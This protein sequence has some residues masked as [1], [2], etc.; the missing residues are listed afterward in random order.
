MEISSFLSIA[1]GLNI[2]VVLDPVE[3]MLLEAPA[4]CQ[5]TKAIYTSGK[6]RDKVESV[7]LREPLNQGK[8]PVRI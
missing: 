6:A 8:A 1:A 4:G 3:V 5:R 2:G 7:G